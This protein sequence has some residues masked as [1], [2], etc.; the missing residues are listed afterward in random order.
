MLAL[1]IFYN[2]LI[3]YKRNC[4]DES[5]VNQKNSRIS[6]S[7][8]GRQCFCGISEDVSINESRINCIAFVLRSVAVCKSI[9][10]SG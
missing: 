5:S 7:L 6:S 1:N 3:P 10:G 4:C 8:D 2:I 9:I